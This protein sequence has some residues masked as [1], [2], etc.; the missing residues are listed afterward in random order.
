MVLPDKTALTALVWRAAE[1]QVQE[2][3]EGGSRGTFAL[4]FIAAGSPLLCE[5]VARGARASLLMGLIG[6]DDALYKQL[7]PRLSASPERA[8]AALEKLKLNTFA[9]DEA[10]PS[11]SFGD[12]WETRRQGGE[13][14]LS[15]QAAMLN[16]DEAPN[17][18]YAH[19]YARGYH[20]DFVVV[21]ATHDIE[22]G[23]EICISYGAGWGAQTD[24]AGRPFLPARRPGGSS[25]AGAQTGSGPALGPLLRD[26]P[27]AMLQR[28]SAYLRSPAGERVVF[29]QAELFSYALPVAWGTSG[30]GGAAVAEVEAEQDR[31]S[32]RR[33]LL[34]ARAGRAALEA[35]ETLLVWNIA[36]LLEG[37]A[38]PSSSVTV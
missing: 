34:A 1:T 20:L 37:R 3:G 9:V 36:E 23:S 2:A 38:P 10:G 6:F 25:P 19:I 29:R 33:M 14:L 12:I 8:L 5:H 26:L 31:G 13:A 22:A 21:V 24:P 7:H 4:K 30:A 27:T 32:L 28:V 15:L 17:A 35:K 18:A 16:H 11:G